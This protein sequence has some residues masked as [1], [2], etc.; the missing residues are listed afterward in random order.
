MSTNGDL[1]KRFDV[2]EKN[3]TERINLFE[4]GTINK[5]NLFAREV[6]RKISALHGCVDRRFEA[7][8]RRFEAVD[9]RFEAM[10]QRLDRGTATRAVE[11]EWEQP[12]GLKRMSPRSRT[13]WSKYWQSCSSSRPG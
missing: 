6:T 10:E 4:E 9:R 5:F 8:D 11:R 12:D 1:N 2:F 3:M 13:S 7:I